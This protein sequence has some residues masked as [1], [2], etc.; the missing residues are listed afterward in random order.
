M[1]IRAKSPEKDVVCLF[2]CLFTP[3]QSMAV[4]SGRIVAAL[5]EL[6]ESRRGRPALPV[7]NSPYGLCGRKVTLNSN[8]VPG[9]VINMKV[10]VAVP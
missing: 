5:Q 4:I 2:V 8:R 6:Y 1:I 9:A 7:P 3:S 10:E